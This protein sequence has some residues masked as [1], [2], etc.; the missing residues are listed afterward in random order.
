MEEAENT[1]SKFNVVLTAL[2]NYRPRKTEYIKEKSIT[3]DNVERLYNKRKIV[4]DAFK[5]KV[6]QFHHEKQEYKD[7][8]EDEDCH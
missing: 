4:N 7:E 6:F 3:L 5:N 1:Q 2:E 8:D